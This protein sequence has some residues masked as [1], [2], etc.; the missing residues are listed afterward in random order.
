MHQLLS[1]FLILVKHKINQLASHDIQFP[2]NFHNIFRIPYSLVCTGWAKIDSISLSYMTEGD[3]NLLYA[4]PVKILEIWSPNSFF[5]HSKWRTRIKDF[6][7]ACYYYGYH[8][9][10]DDR[11]LTGYGFMAANMIDE[12]AKIRIYWNLHTSRY[13]SSYSVTRI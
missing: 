12:K 8:C 10:C 3:C 13:S 1:T 11:A 7:P 4:F 2:R 6:V 9:S 5:P